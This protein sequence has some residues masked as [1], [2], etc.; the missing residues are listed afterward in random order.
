M[1]SSAAAIAS[2]ASAFSYSASES[3]P[4]SSLARRKARSVSFLRAAAVVDVRLG[5]PQM[6]AGLLQLG[7]ERKV[8]QLRQ[9]G[10]LLDPAAVIDRLA[11]VVGVRAETLDAGDDLR[12]HV[13]GLHRLDRPRG[14]H[15][16][17]QVAA[18]DRQRAEL[19]PRPPGCRPR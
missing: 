12:P 14:G 5:K 4:R 9:H 15:A 3:V 16:D 11:G 1:A 7:L 2:S 17:E 18:H 8:V 6:D 13:D 19:R 10:P